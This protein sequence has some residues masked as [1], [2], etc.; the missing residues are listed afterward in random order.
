MDSEDGEVHGVFSRW[1]E[2]KGAKTEKSF[3]GGRLITKAWKEDTEKPR[4]PMESLVERE[5]TERRGFGLGSSSPCRL[6][7]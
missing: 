7:K 2:A 3:K 1:R 4:R 5:A 6:H